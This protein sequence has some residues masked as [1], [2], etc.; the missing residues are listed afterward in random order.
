MHATKNLQTTIHAPI[1][2]EKYLSIPHF[3]IYLK[4][5]R[6]DALDTKHFYFFRLLLCANQKHKG[7]NPQIY[8]NW[9]RSG[10]M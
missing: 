2:H 3:F 7:H 9:G 4:W 10:I 1:R 6:K 5:G 8:E